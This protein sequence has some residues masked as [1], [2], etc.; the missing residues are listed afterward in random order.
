MT[1]PVLKILSYNIH[2]G[3]SAGNRRF[4][5]DQIKQSIV[6]LEANIVFLQ[7]VV[8]EHSL[9]AARIEA[10]PTQSQFEFLADE[11]WSHYAYGKN[12]VY[13]AGHHG[14]AIL[15]AFPILSWSN[16]NISSSGFESRGLLHVELELPQSKNSLEPEART[17]LHCFCVHLSLTQGGR[18]KQIDSIAE[19]ITKI[20]GS[21]A[22]FILAGDFN[23]WRQRVSDGLVDRLGASE[24]FMDLHG[25]HARTYPSALP[26]LCLDRIYVRGLRIIVGRTLRGTPWQQLSDHLALYAEVEIA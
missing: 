23:D 25:S 4:I 22:P 13:S 18:R 19:I 17:V 6:P 11:T 2:K 21:T 5:L 14:N 24:V 9:H 3:F 16:S 20:V 1:K 26:V 12:A 10:W 15:S 7:E 8:G